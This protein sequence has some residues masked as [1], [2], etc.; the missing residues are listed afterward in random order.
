MLR[1]ASAFVSLVSTT[2]ASTNRTAK[3]VTARLMAE[4]APKLRNVRRV[5]LH[6][7]NMADMLPTTSVFAGERLNPSALMP[8]N[9]PPLFHAATSGSTPFRF[10]P[11]VGDL[12]HSLNIGPTGAGKSTLLGLLA[13]GGMQQA[14]AFGDPGMGGFLNQFGGGCF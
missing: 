4:A 9:S 12:G 1:S 11:H 8:P 7:L 13:G 14:N 2:I 5:V 6:T 3:T 10:N